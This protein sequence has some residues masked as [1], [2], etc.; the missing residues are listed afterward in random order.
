MHGFWVLLGNHRAMD[1]LAVEL[2]VWHVVLMNPFLLCI[3]HERK[4]ENAVSSNS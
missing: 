1:A 3:C 4:P 2:G